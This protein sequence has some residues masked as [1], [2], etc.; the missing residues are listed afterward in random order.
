M[1]NKLEMFLYQLR[2]THPNFEHLFKNGGCYHLWEIVRTVFPDA[3]CMYDRIDGHVYIEL[4]GKLYDISGRIHNM[5]LD[6]LED[7]E[8]IYQELKPYR[9][10]DGIEW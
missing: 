9:W 1:N 5:D 4:Y 3:K 10:K 7:M 6:E 2:E 8:Y